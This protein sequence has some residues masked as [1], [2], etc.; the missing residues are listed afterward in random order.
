MNMRNINKFLMACIVVSPLLSSCKKFVEVDPPGDQLASDAVFETDQTAIG[1][2][3]GI[4]TSM[5]GNFG[6]FANW[7]PT[8]VGGLSSDEFKSNTAEL[9]EENALNQNAV[10]PANSY[11]STL[12]SEG[13]K[14]IYQA[15]GIIDGASKSKGMSAAVIS[16]LRGEAFCHFYLVNYFGDIPYITATDYHANSNEPRIPVADIYQK[17]EA[18]LLEAQQLLNDGFDASAGERTRPNKGAA[19]ALLARLYL[20]MSEWVNAETQAAMLIDNSSLYSLPADLNEVFLKNSAETIWQLIPVFSGLNTIEGFSITCCAITNQSM[21]DELVNAFDSQDKRLTDWVG[22]VIDG[23]RI[24][25]YPFKYK[26]GFGDLVEYYMVLRLAE[27]YLIRAEA[28]VNQGNIEGAAA[29]LNVIRI[30]AGLPETD[31]TDKPSL[32]L[33]IEQER[34]IELFSEWGHRWFDLKRTGRA[35]EVLSAI[36]PGWQDFDILYPIPTGQILNAPNFPQN[37]G[38]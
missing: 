23:S 12:W 25:Y 8:L 37:P 22:T 26:V 4:Y 6:G 29:D 32:L 15:N 19:T 36:K 7:Y 30:R 13:Y 17:I 20:Y 28:R 24:F 11:I 1:A 34:R 31:A 33:A 2:M 16:Q 3:V 38:Y 14:F 27:Q 5:T 10:T 9:V 18:D 35:N 21:R